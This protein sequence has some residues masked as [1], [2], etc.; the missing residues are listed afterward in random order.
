MPRT[1]YVLG[2]G[3]YHSSNNPSLIYYDPFQRSLFDDIVI[4]LYYTVDVIDFYENIGGSK[5]QLG[6]AGQTRT[7][8][9]CDMVCHLLLVRII[10]TWLRQLTSIG[11][12]VR[13][14]V[15]Y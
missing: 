14:R 15:N 10:F 12:D 9:R 13:I 3:K 7:H 8:A 4:A 11:Q 1:V 5:T 6:I 2:Q